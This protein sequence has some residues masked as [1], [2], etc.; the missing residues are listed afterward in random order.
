[1]AFIRG[2]MKVT[3]AMFHLDAV[4]LSVPESVLPPSALN[5]QISG[6]L[7][8]IWPFLD[9]D[10]DWILQNI[11][12]FQQQLLGYN[13]LLDCIDEVRL[14]IQHH[15]DAVHR[16]MVTYSSTLTPIWCLLH[17]IFCAVI[18]EVQISL[19]CNTGDESESESESEDYQ[20]LDF[21]QGLWK[22]S[23]VCGAWR[24][25]VLS[26]PQLWSHIVLWSPMETPDPTVPALQAMILHLTQH[27]LDIMF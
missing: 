17:E 21:S 14:E 11:E 4:A 9:T 7:C 24:D 2:N 12:L 20:M 10:H 25:I 16:S 3:D 5:S 19:W 6:I 13:A 22:L 1:M 15:H 23:H 8:A 27:P 18:H 26:Y